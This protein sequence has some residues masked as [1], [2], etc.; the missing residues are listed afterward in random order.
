MLCAVVSEARIPRLQSWEVQTEGLYIKQTFNSDG[1]TLAVAFN[2]DLTKNGYI[3]AETM[4]VHN[5]QLAPAN[6][7]APLWGN[8]DVLYSTQDVDATK[9]TFAGNEVSPYVNIQGK[10]EFLLREEPLPMADGC[11]SMISMFLGY[12]FIRKCMWSTP[13]TI[14][15]TAAS[16]KKFYKSMLIH[17][18]IKTTDYKNLCLIIKEEMDEW[19]EDCRKYNEDIDD[20][21]FEDEYEDSEEYAAGEDEQ[22]FSPAN[23]GA[24]EGFK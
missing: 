5:L 14:K 7:A 22:E 4:N 10:N 19:Q 2:Q 8:Y 13:G 21:S 6:G 23:S 9:N 18:Y 16:I 11:G 3:Q 1:G 15:K 20:M 12:F 17:D 24:A